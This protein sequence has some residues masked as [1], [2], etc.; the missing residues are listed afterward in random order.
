MLI[1]SFCHKTELQLFAAT[2]YSRFVIFAVALK[3][4]WKTLRNVYVF[5]CFCVGKYFVAMQLR[6][7]GHTVISR[8]H[9]VLD[10]KLHFKT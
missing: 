7:R 9:Q 6:S 2:C 4:V 8:T 10:E 3:K 1:Y 5:D